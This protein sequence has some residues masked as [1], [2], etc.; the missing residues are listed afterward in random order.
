MSEPVQT[1]KATYALIAEQFAA[2]V[3]PTSVGLDP[4]LDYLAAA[5]PGGI[6]A[7]IGCGPG[8]HT[9]ALRD[10]GLRAI[11]LDLSDAML[12][13]GGLTGVAQADMRFLPLR[14]GSLDAIWCQAAFLHIPRLYA[15]TVLSEFARAVR[16]G[17]KLHIAVAEGDGEGYEVAANYGSEARRWFTFYR[18]ENLT[19]LLSTAGFSVLSTRR[20]TFHRDWLTLHASR[21]LR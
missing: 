5:V 13:V 12:R 14:T 19:A 8:Y 10:R 16:P 17:G 4:D 11:G 21:L 2:L 15:P 7:D 6:V 18:A 20:S 3:P 9:Q 1:T